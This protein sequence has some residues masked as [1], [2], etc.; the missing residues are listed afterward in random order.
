MN[1]KE[2]FTEKKLNELKAELGWGFGKQI[3]EIL[4]EQYPERKPFAIPAIYKGL[5]FE[6]R[7]ERIILAALRLKQKREQ[8]M[9]DL[10]R[11]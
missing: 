6:H 3:Q 9:K 11:T 7:S 4:K 1:I 8:M 2:E 5:T 10:V